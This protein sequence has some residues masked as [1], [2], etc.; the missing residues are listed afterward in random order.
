MAV[1]TETKATVAPPLAS[2]GDWLRRAGRSAETVVIPAL[3]IVAAAILFSLFLLVLGQSP[4]EFFEL[5]WRGG[6]GTSFSWQNTLVRSAPLIFTA[7]CVAV[8][9]RLGM[10]I[11]GGEG[12][13]VLAGFSAAAIAVPLVD[14]ASRGW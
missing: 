6:F 12:A 1:T 5:L 11:I 14:W 13:F 4:A 7:L 9:A 2:G 8:P 10:V 3:A